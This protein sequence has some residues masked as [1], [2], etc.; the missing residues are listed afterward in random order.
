MKISQTVHSFAPIRR[1]TLLKTLS[2]GAMAPFLEPLVSRVEAET[3]GVRPRRVVFYVEGNGMSP[4]HIQPAGI[5]R[6]LMTNQGGG[7]PHTDVAKLVDCALSAPGLGLPD[8]LKPLERHLKRL[9]VV[10]GLSGRVCGGGHSNFFGALG[11]YP[12]QAGAKDTTIDAALARA[13]PSIFQH[14]ALGFVTNPTP[15]AAPIFYACSASG[16]NAKVPHYQDP[17]LAYN[18]LFGKILGGNSQSVVGT[19]SMLLDFMA[20]DIR[21]LA[22]QLP[23]EEAQKLQRYADAFHSIGKRQTRLGE[24]NVA[25]IPQRRDDLYGSMLETKRMEAHV[26]IAATALITGLTNTVTLC[27]GASNYPMWKG[28]GA[29]VDNH[30][31]AHESGDS[32]TEMRRNDAAAM[33]VKI[34]QF[35]TGLIARLVDQLE[36]VPE[37]NGTMM[38]NTLIVYLSDS[39]E[40][41]HCSCY[42][43]PVVLLG[44]LGGRLKAGDRFLNLP[45]YFSGTQHATMGQFYASLLH[46]AGAPVAQFG[47]KDR[48][49]LQNGH[50]QDTPWTDILA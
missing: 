47:M 23:Y 9:T 18:M 20:S 13:N 46:A 8:P 29:S 45:H 27:A 43:W 39:A 38:D 12:Q 17:I 42:E 35:N 28:V 4:V 7:N 50:K 3:S 48:V 21:G 25:K 33:R 41:H 32:P 5:E 15:T 24:I 40:G 37:G 44:N 19:Q 31:L 14:L 16:P 1:R 36:A 11:A 10:Q 2:L 30:A 26:E 22:S 6:K 34:R 49:L